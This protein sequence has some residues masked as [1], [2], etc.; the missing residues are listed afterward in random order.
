MSAPRK[1]KAAPR[2]AG[3]TWPR[4]WCGGPAQPVGEPALVVQ[5]DLDT[6]NAA[7]AGGGMGKAGWAKTHRAE[8]AREAFGWHF[9]FPDD[10]M[11]RLAASG[12]WCVRL[13][14]LCSSAKPL[15]TGGLWSALKAVEDCVA[16]MLET[17]DGS[18]AFGCVVA[19]ERRHGALGVRVEIWNRGSLPLAALLE[20]AAAGTKIRTLGES[21]AEHQR[22]AEAD[23]LGGDTARRL[24]AAW[25][26]AGSVPS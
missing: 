16:A 11:V 25:P 3:P 18:P 21:R 6:R 1:P 7:N 23:D 4:E 10:R 9:L 22:L 24:L 13:T 14:R 19:Q 5:F 26:D 8:A 12:P 20:V 15:D 17:D 2:A